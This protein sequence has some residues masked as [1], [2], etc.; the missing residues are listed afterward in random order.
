MPT[1]A[2]TRTEFRV[3]GPLEV[4]DGE[5]GLVD[6]GGPVQRSLLSRLLIARGGVVPVG[7]L[8]DDVYRG[9]PPACAVAT[10][11][12]HVSRLRRAVEPG[13]APRTPPCLLISRPPGYALAATD[14]DALRFEELVRNAEG[15]PAADALPLL[16]EAL[17]LWRG[18]PYGEFCDEPW[19][20]AEVDRLWEQRAAAVERRAQALLDL[21]R[22]QA[23]IGDLEGETEAN[24]SR[25]RLW[26]L[27]ALA[28]YRTGR[29]ADA[30]AVLR[31]A[32]SRPG[33]R[34]GTASGAA[35]RTL[36]ADILRHAPC[37]EPVLAA[38]SHT[39]V[40][41]TAVSH[42][43]VSHTAVSHAAEARRERRPL[44]GRERELAELT[45]MRPGTAPVV[46]A[47]SGE[48][49]I[50][51][52][53]LLAAFRED[54][55]RLGHLV[56]WGGCDDAGEARPFGPWRQVLRALLRR[57]PPA[58]RSTLR[59]LLD[60]V[61]PAGTASARRGGAVARCLAAA[62]REQPL[63]VVLDDLHRA[64]P[65]SVE[66]LGD[67]MIHLRAV[68]GDTPVTVVAAF[69]CSPPPGTTGHAAEDLLCALA[70][71]DLVR[72]RLEGLD[73]RAVRALAADA[74]VTLDEPAARRLAERTG[75]NPFFLREILSGRARGPV[76][77]TV[78]AAVAELVRR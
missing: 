63:V 23:V 2:A 69:R 26:C 47:V 11:R 65:A 49:G 28:L 32:A 67:V 56:L 66:L 43:A 31:R 36:E 78:P 64:D 73:S 74:G 61:P 4:H 33:R 54:R 34:P 25:E 37:L 24:P 18:I 10:L 60:D 62:A 9:A 75:G 19:A 30:L 39:A 12:A 15:R 77:A 52:T 71:Y 55:A 46:A 5:S 59:D 13:R 6:L 72:V 22:P 3:L 16:D 21:D 14:V 44:R 27:L 7:R 29:Q 53:A 76:A 38:V 68:P 40:S 70:R 51:K 58:D 45:T 1:D 35:L 8:V 50:G 41:H 57:C 42:T 17:G 20:V 48:P